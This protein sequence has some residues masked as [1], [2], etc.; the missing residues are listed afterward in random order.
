MDNKL[1][2]SINNIINSLKSN[3]E[4]PIIN[5]FEVHCE[6]CK[7]YGVTDDSFDFNCFLST[8]LDITIEEVDE[9][10]PNNKEDRI[11]F[12]CAG[13]LKKEL[14]ALSIMAQADYVSYVMQKS[15]PKTHKEIEREKLNHKGA[16]Q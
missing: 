6:W 9:S 16:I 5:G 4:N 10:F 11:C 1:I 8:L 12:Q 14:R 15:K 2:T 13:I 7:F 3:I